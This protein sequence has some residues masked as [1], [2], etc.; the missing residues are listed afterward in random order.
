MRSSQDG[1][2]APEPDPAEGAVVQGVLCKREHF[3]D[4]DA[5][6]C[7]VCGISMVQLTHNLVE[8]VR[9][10]LGVLVLDSGATYTLDADYVIGREPE[11]DELVR[12]EKARPLM[13]V[14][15]DGTV[16][17]VHALVTLEGWEVRIAD[18]GSTNGTF[19]GSDDPDRWEPVPLGSAVT[20]RPGARVRLGQRTLVFDSHHRG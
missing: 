19:L 3:N 7:A 9:P 2:A 18:R 20:L 15:P 10:P 12:G 4:P 16:S 11:H 1:A 5:R 6:Y 8:G 17:R 14:D 13:I